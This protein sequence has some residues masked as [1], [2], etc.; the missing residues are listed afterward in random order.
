VLDGTLH[1][2]GDHVAGS[3]PDGVH[4][5]IAEQPCV[6]PVLDEPVA[7]AHLHALGCA[8]A[9]AFRAVHLEERSQQTERRGCL[10]VAGVGLVGELGNAHGGGEPGDG[11]HHQISK[12]VAHQRVQVKSPPER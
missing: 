7:T 1:V 6:G 10:M 5:D 3:L 9:S 4:V 12:G 2:E 8:D 11:V